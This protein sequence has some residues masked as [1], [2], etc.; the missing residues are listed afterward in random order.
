MVASTRK[1]NHNGIY[2]QCIFN[3][4]ISVADRKDLRVW[5]FSFAIIAKIIKA[6]LIRQK[7]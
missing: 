6:V 1:H 3:W 7:Q 4:N 5:L 2:G